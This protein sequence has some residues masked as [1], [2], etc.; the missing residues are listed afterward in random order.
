MWNRSPGIYQARIAILLSMTTLTQKL[1]AREFL[2]LPEVQ[3][4]AWLELVNGEVV[5]MP[6]PNKRHSYAATVLVQI[7][8]AYVRT[9]RAGLLYFELDTIFGDD[10]VRVPDLLFL[11]KEHPSD[12][13]E[14]LDSIPDLCIEILSPSNARTDR[15]DKFQFYQSKGVACYWIVDPEEQTI[16]AYTLENGRYVSAGRG[17]GEQVIKLPPFPELEIPLKELWHPKNPD[18]GKS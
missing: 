15:V 18:A 3:A 17:A 2:E 8:G 11:R 5:S 1:T 13:D 7:L 9:Q 10:D 16:E 4:G 12:P 14:P 6:R